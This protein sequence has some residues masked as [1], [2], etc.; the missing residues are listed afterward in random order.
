MEGLF[1]L[2]VSMKE[3]QF[4]KEIKEIYLFQ[5]LFGASC[6]KE[7]R[8]KVDAVRDIQKQI[9]QKREEGATD[10]EI[11]GLLAMKRE[12]KKQLPVVTVS[13]MFGS[14]FRQ[15]ELMYHTG[16]ICVDIDRQDN[17]QTDMEEIKR[18]IRSLS[19]VAYCG[20]SSSGSGLFCIIPI[21]KDPELHGDIFRGLQEDFKNCGIIIDRQCG[22]INRTRSLSYD[23]SPYI[24]PYA[25]TY[26]R[27]AKAD[28]RSME[29]IQQLTKD[30]T[31]GETK[32]HI[33]T[34]VDYIVQNRIDITYFS[35][36]EWFFILKGIYKAFEDDL[37][38]GAELAV[39]VSQ[40]YPNFNEKETRS[41]YYASR[42]NPTGKSRGVGSFFYYAK[43]AGV[44]VDDILK[45]RT[46][47]QNGNG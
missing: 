39:Q 6:R 40:F 46:E 16:L 10:E 22:N 45:D 38:T 21:P 41:V 13:G 32:D 37:E 25:E 3:T 2:A 34:V 20:R 47:P 19:C 17:P 14:S 5:F 1:N 30:W 18:K 44:P 43:K 9:D 12:Q 23:D 8:T 35:Q 29:Q 28:E 15:T 27:T 26:N 42:A 24:N 31:P 11:K 4:G 33:K 7:L 36:L